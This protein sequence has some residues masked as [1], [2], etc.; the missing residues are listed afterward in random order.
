MKESY[1]LRSMIG[2]TEEGVEERD[3]GL[4][5]LEVIILEFESRD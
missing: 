4:G 5:M 2:V 3:T 1:W